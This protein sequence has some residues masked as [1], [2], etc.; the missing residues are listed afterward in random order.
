M[1]ALI[2]LDDRD[3]NPITLHDV[4]GT[5]KRSAITANGLMGGYVSTLRDDKAVLPQAHGGINNTRYTDGASPSLVLE[6]MGDSLGDCQVEYRAMVAPMLQTLDYGP[7]LL[8][9]TESSGLQLQRL[10]KLDSDLD[11]TIQ[12]GGALLTFQVSFYAEDPR[13]YTQSV[14][15]ASTSAISNLVPNGSFEAD[16]PGSAP[17]SWTV[18]SG[19]FSTNAVNNEIPAHWTYDGSHLLRLVATLSPGASAVLESSSF[20]VTAGDDYMA[21][22]GL[23]VDTIP[24][25][26]WLGSPP[27]GICLSVEQFATGGASLGVTLLDIATTAPTVDPAA[28]LNGRFTAAPTAATA[29]II[30]SAVNASSGTTGTLFDFNVD[31]VTCALLPKLVVTNNGIRDTGFTIAL[32]GGGMHTVSV[33][34]DGDVPFFSLRLQQWLQKSSDVETIYVNKEA[35]IGDKTIIRTSG[36]VTTDDVSVL[37]P[38]TAIWGYLPSG[39]STIEVVGLLVGGSFAVTFSDAY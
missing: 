38:R 20:A 6:V 5:S 2:T 26:E 39:D 9:W 34:G 10:V 25:G 7:A 4:S 36:G 35:Y 12:G 8:K 18:K 23:Q 33:V 17:A 15:T 27:S 31:G 29:K 24:T 1:I 13:A 3:G 19:T 37:D 14:T 22:T 32:T 11:P 28:A 16:S 30:I 21:G